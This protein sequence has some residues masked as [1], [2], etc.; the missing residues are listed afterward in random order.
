MPPKVNDDVKASLKVDINFKE[1]G[2][3]N[4]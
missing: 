4:E 2:T 1:P 3:W